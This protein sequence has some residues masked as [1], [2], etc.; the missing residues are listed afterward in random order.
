MKIG[1]IIS[2]LITIGI[3]KY[4]SGS[5]KGILI[6]YLLSSVLVIASL[7]IFF[8]YYLSPKNIKQ[9]MRFVTLAKTDVKTQIKF[10]F[11]VSFLPVLIAAY[12]VDL[13]DLPSKIFTLLPNAA[14][15]FAVLNSAIS[16]VNMNTGIFEK[17]DGGPEF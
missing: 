15:E 2:L 3:Y 10:I 9:L 6:Y 8:K 14:V 1:W 16:F 11:F 4:L 12:F 17:I 7:F 5:F 13:S